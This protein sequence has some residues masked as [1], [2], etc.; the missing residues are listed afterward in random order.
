[1]QKAVQYSSFVF[2]TWLVLI[3]TA[4]GQKTFNDTVAD[5]KA[6][7][8]KLDQNRR[9]IE[10][11]VTL[12]R[13]T[14]PNNAPK[15]IF[16][17]DDA[18]AAR[19][20]KLDEIVADRHSELRKDRLLPLQT[21]LAQ[22]YGQVFPTNNITATLGTYD[23]TN[24]IVPITFQTTGLLHNTTLSVT[25]NV[26]STL[27]ANWAQVVKTGYIS[28]DPGYRPALAM[29][30][31]TYPQIWPQG[32]ILTF[33][34][35]IYNL[36]NNHAI[37]FSQDGVYFVT[38]SNNPI[39]PLWSVST[40]E[41]FRPIQFQHGDRVYAVAFSPNGQFV[42]T[43]GNDETQPDGGK[44]VL[45][46]M[47]FGT[48][49]RTMSHLGR[50][51]A[52]NFSPDGQYL[53]TTILR[54]SKGYLHLWNVMSGQL[55]WT[56]AYNASESTIHALAFSPDGQY[57]A[58]GNERTP[59]THEKDTAILWNVNSGTKAHELEH[60]EGVYS[61]TFSPNGKYLATGNDGSATLWSLLRQREIRQ[62]PH[63][64]LVYATAFSPGGEYL[65]NGDNNGTITFWRVG[66]E[67]ITLTTEITKE[68]TIS[69][70]GE[71]TDLVWSPGGN[72]ISDSN[73]VYRAILYPED[74]ALSAVVVDPPPIEVPRTVEPPP[75]TQPVPNVG[76]EKTLAQKVFEKYSLTLQQAELQRFLPTVLEALKDPAVQS[77][78]NP[79]T[80]GLL[81]TTPDLLR[82]LIPDVEEDFITLLKENTELRTMLRDPDVQTL[83]QDPD[84]IAEFTALIGGDIP[85]Q[86]P[87]TQVPG[88]QRP[89][90]VNGDGT[91]DL[92]DVTLVAASLGQTGQNAVDVNNDG[93]VDVTDLVL[94]VTAMA[95]AGAAP[96]MFSLPLETLTAADVQ[97]LLTQAQQL[98]LSDPTVQK[99]IK[100][101]QQLLAALTPEETALLPNYPNPF[102]PETW[103]PYQLAEAA[104]VTLTLHAAD[105]RLIRTLTLGH[106]P[107]GSYQTRHRAAYWDGQNELGEPVASGIYFCTLTAGEFT[108]TR[109]MLIRK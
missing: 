16:E 21:Q 59:A 46:E 89:E 77:L 44:A 58:T 30:K 60:E 38:G 76:Q 95:S 40:G 19:L 56:K 104:D 78:L 34:D 71:V 72:L 62:L 83:L 18:Y 35:E 63:D 103:I 53:A 43:V 4:L 45:W 26:A 29:V 6:L 51:R 109:K 28:I 64:D 54:S 23:A 9:G 33:K 94:V 80:I 74:E 25:P 22:L 81:I 69:T 82:Q 61:V 8:A 96:S 92:Q 15:N 68:K 66:T 86:R 65:A 106:Q 105:G 70:R 49:V 91:V 55:I 79:T 31:L 84:A 27:Q 102:N 101:L 11:D 97:H 36:G 5:I 32:L 67:E 2:F 3:S 17:T 42:A 50:V 39:A 1:M 20:R 37:A 107:A 93:V 14:H 85:T 75:V 98:D 87:D 108:A 100:V 10:A 48:Q 90:D 12:L 47:T 57:L 7:E 13:S 99:G 88:A 73:T 24:Q 41:K 52:V